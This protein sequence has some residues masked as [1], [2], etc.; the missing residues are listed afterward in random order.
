[1]KRILVVFLGLF[2]LSGL[3]SG[4]VPEWEPI[5]GTEYNMVIFN[6]VTVNGE[7]FTDEG[8][9]MLA[10]FGPGGEDDCRAL[11]GFV[12][13]PNVWNMTAVSTVTA[14]EDLSFKV[15]LANSDIV[16]DCQESIPFVNNTTV[17]GVDDPFGLSAIYSF[18]H[19][20]EIVLPEEFS[21]NEDQSILEDFS[22]Y[23]ND[24]DEEDDLI[25]SCENSE[26]LTV[27]IT[28]M[29]VSITPDANWNGTETLT[30]AVDDQVSG[31]AEADVEIVILP[32][33]DA[34]EFNLPVG[35]SFNED[36]G[37]ELDI[38]DMIWDV[39][40]DDLNILATGDNICIDVL[41]GIATFS[42]TPDWSGIENVTFFADDGVYREM[43]MAVVEVVVTAVNDAP[44]IVGYLPET[45]EIEFVE[46]GSVDFSIEGEDIDSEISYQWLVN[47]IE[48]GTG[49]ELY[50]EFTEVG[51][52][53]VEAVVSD[54]EF[55][56]S[57]LWTVEIME[58]PGLYP[59][60][61]EVV[62]YTN[63][64]VAYCEVTIDGAA[65]ADDD[66]V[67]AFVGDECRGVG[68]IV[69]NNDITVSTMNIQ[70]E[71]LEMI[72]FTVYDASADIVYVSDF[73]VLS[74]PGGDIG[75]PPDLLPVE[76]LTNHPPMIELPQEISLQEDTAE[77][78]DFSYYVSD[79][80]ED[81]L[82]LTC[83]HE[84]NLDVAVDG[85]NVTI[86]PDANW[87]GDELV[88]F[89]VSDDSG[90][91]I[92]EDS[93]NI[94]VFSV[95]DLP[96]LISPLTIQ[97]NENSNYYFQVE[98]GD[99]E[100][101]EIG[102][103]VTGGNNFNINLMP[104]G[105]YSLTNMANWYGED[106]LTVVLTDS[107]GGI[108]EADIS[109]T[110][111]HV[112]HAPQGNHVLLNLN[113]NEYVSLDL[114]D[115]FTDPDGDELTY[116][117]T[118]QYEHLE[119]ELSG[120][121]IEIIPLE[122]SSYHQC[123]IL[124]I[125]D[126]G[127]LSLT[128]GII[129][130]VRE[131]NEPPTA[132]INTNNIVDVQE[133]TPEAIQLYAVDDYTSIADM[134]F[135]IVIQPQHGIFEFI[136]NRRIS[137][138]IEENY[139]GTDNFAVVA[140]DEEGA[141]S[142]TVNC[143]IYIHSV[144]DAPE[145][146]PVVNIWIDS[147]ILEYDFSGNISD[148]ET[149]TEDLVFYPVHTS[150]DDYVAVSGIPY[151]VSGTTI[152]YIMPEN[153]I[154]DIILF[155]I[156][157][158]E[159]E[160]STPEVV[161]VY[162]AGNENT[163]LRFAPLAIDGEFNL[164]YG[165]S[166]DV[167]FSGIDI[168][169]PYE[170]LGIEITSDLQYGVLDDFAFLEYNEPLTTY[171]GS[172][173]P[174]VNEDVTE[175]INFRV[176]GNDGED[177]GT[178]TI[179]ITAGDIAPEIEEISD[180]ELL[181]DT[182]D[183][184]IIN[185]TNPDEAMNLDFWSISSLP[186]VNSMFSFGELTDTT[187]EVVVNPEAD[188]FGT[189]F[190]ELTC[191][192]GNGL[193]DSQGFILT[194]INDNDAPEINLPD[195]F[196]LAE[197]SQL[198]ESFLGY[199]IDIDPDSLSLSVSIAGHLSIEITQILVNITPDAD[200][201]G[202]EMVTFTVNDNQGRAIASDD[203]NIIVTPVNDDPQIDLPASITLME[204]VPE[205][206]DFTPYLTDIDGDVL[207][208][209]PFADPF[210]M[211]SIEGYDV[212]LTPVANWSGITD[213][214]FLVTD[215][216]GGD[217][218]FGAT[219]VTVIEVNDA[220]VIELP[221][222]IEIAEDSSEMID[223]SAY[224]SDLES[225]NLTLSVTG[226][227]EVQVDIDDLEVTFTPSENYY[228]TEMLTF[229]VD[230]NQGRLMASDTVTLDITAVNDAPVIESFEPSEQNI[231]G[232]LNDEITFNVTATDI[233]SELEY[234][235]LIDDIDQNNPEDN[236]TMIFDEP[237]VF[238]VRVDVSDG[239]NS[240]FVVWQVTIAS[241][242]NYNRPWVPVIY[243][244]STVAY[245]EVLIDGEAA[246]IDD[247]VGAFVNYECRGVGEV[248]FDGEYSYATMNIQ[249][250]APEI[251]NFAIYDASAD[252]VLVSE[253]TV[254]SNPGG[255]IGYPPDYLPVYIGE[256]PH[257]DYARPWVPVIYTNSTVAYCEVMINGAAAAVGDEVG[258]F[259]NLECRGVGE[260]FIEREG[261]FATMNIQGIAAEL[262]NFAIYDASADEVLLSEFTVMSNPGGDIGYPPDY[263]P[264][265]I[266]EVPPGDYARP[267]VPVI[268]TNST[269]AYCE[270]MI[271][272]TAADDDDEVGAFVN[273]E[274]RG[275]GD[276]FIDGEHS[277][278]TMNI[279]GNTPELINFAIYNASADE[280]LVSEFTAMSNPGGD[281]GYPPDLLV[282]EVINNHNP[283][284]DLP[285][286][287]ELDEDT[288]LT[289]DFSE[290]ITDVDED[291][292]TLSTDYS[293]FLDISITGLSVIVTPQANWNGQ[294]SV[295]FTVSD[296]QDR[297]I[298]EDT[299][300]FQVNPVNDLPFLVSPLAITFNEDQSSIFTI[301]T[302]DVDNEQVSA[303]LSVGDELNLTLLASNIYRLRS[304]SENWN[305]TTTLWVNLNDN[306]GG[307]VDVEVPVTVNPVNDAP[308]GEYTIDLE[309]GINQ[310]VTIDL[311]DYFNDS[312]GDVLS[313]SLE[314]NYIYHM[315]YELSGS[316]LTLTPAAGFT[317]RA[318][319]RFRAADPA[320]LFTVSAVYM[321][322]IP[323]NTPPVVIN[324]STAYTLMEDQAKS[325]ELLVIDD[326]D[327]Y[328]DLTF[329]ITNP[330]MH[331][332]VTIEDEYLIYEPE[333]NYFGTDQVEIVVHDT[334][335]GTSVPAVFNYMVSP[336]NDRPVSMNREF[337]ITGNT[338]DYDLTEDIFDV[339]TANELL[340]FDSIIT[341]SGDELL[342]VFDVEYT[343]SDWNL[344]YEMPES[345]DVD[346]ICYTLSDAQGYVSRVYNIRIYREGSEGIATRVEPMAING[347][348]WLDYD[349]NM[350]IDF[351]GLD[352]T[353]PMEQLSIEI[354]TEPQYGVLSNFGFFEFNEPLTTYLGNYQPTVNEDI[355]DEIGFRVWGDDGEAFGT[356]S[357]HIAA[358]SIA[359]E[360]EMI[361]D[362]E[363][364]EET[365]GS[366][367][368]N[369]TNPDEDASLDLWSIV[370]IPD[371]NEM[372]SF[373]EITDTTLELEVNPSLDYFGTSLVVITCTDGDGLTDSEGFYL[374]IIN[375]N[376]APE[377]DLP[378]MISFNEDEV[379][380]AYFGIFVNDVD[381]DNLSLSSELAENIQ[382]DII[383]FIV[384]FTPNEDW[385]GSEVVTFTI[386]DNQG[387]AIASDDVIIQ[388]LAVNDDPEINLPVV[389]N[390]MEDI[391]ET[392]DFS[393]YIYDADGDVVETI[394]FANNN[395]MIEVDGYLVTLTPLANWSGTTD[396]A[397]LADDN[398]GGQSAFG[399]TQVIVA[400]VND[401]PVMDLPASVLLDEDSST[402]IDLSDYI[403]DVEGDDLTLSVS[404]NVEIAVEID[405][406]AVTFIP[407]ENYNGSE[408][409]T[410]VVDDNQ[411]RLITTDDMEVIVSP[412]NDEPVIIG[413]E[414]EDQD[415][416]ID[417]ETEISFSVSASDID[418]D[419]EYQWFLNGIDQ[420]NPS[421]E[422]AINFSLAGIYSVSV[423]ISDEEYT[424]SVS[425]QV[426]YS[427]PEDYS[428]PWIPVIYT[429][430]TVAYCEILIEN[431][432]AAEGDEVGAFVN[433]ECRGVGEIFIDSDHSY[434]TMNIQ[435]NASELVNFAV[436][437]ASADEVLLSEFTAMSNP[438]GDIGY[439]P[440]YLPVHIGGGVQGDYARPWVPV[441]YTNS[442][443]AYCQVMIDGENAA[444][445]DEVGA[446]VNYECRGVGEV[447]MEREA[448]YATM[449]IQGEMP[450]LVNFAVY[451]ASADEVLLSEFTAMSNPGG[452]I[453][454]PPNYLPVYIGGGVQGDYA[455]PWVPVIYTNS[456]VA[457]CQ[458]MIDGENAAS[459]DEVGAFVNYECRGVGEVFMEREASYATMNIQGEMPE[460]V[461][462]AVY[463][464]SADEV[465]LSEFT[466]MSN[467]GG[468]IGYPPNYLPVYIGGGVQGDYARPWVPVIYTNSTVAY[469]QVMIDGENAVAGDEVG[470]FVN[471]E[472]RGVGEVFMEREASYATMNIQGEMPELVNFAVYDVSADEVLISE[473]TAMSNPGYDIGYPPAYL[474]VY[475]GGVVQGDYARPWVPVIYTNSTVAYCQVMIDGE[476][477]ASGDEVG[478]FV[479]Y[480]CR[481]V[482]EVFIEREASYATMNIQGELPE[483]V[484]F[485]VYDASADEVLISEFTAMS[486]PGYDIGYPP[487]YLPV[488]VG[489]VQGD[490]ARPWVPV[491]YT[492]STVAYCQVMID[493][494]N[495]ASGDEVGAFVN[496]ECRGVG[497]V[498]ME[499][500]A[501]Y[502]TM[503]IQGE[504]PELVNFAV[505]DASAD[506]VL[507][508]E[509]TAM[510]NPGYDI[511]YPPAYLPVYVGGVQGDYARP[512]VPVIY[513]N[514]T[515][516]YCQVMI[517]GENAVSGD[518]VGAFV[519]YECRGVGEVFM[520]REASYATMNIQGEMPELVNFAVYDVSADEVLISEFTA[521][522]NP[523]YDIGYPPA[524]LPVYVGG[525]VQGDYARPWVPVIYTNSTVAYCQVMIDGEN[526][527][528]GDE[529]G[530]FVNYE[531]RGVGEVF[532]EREASYATMN[533]QGEMPEL[534]N[535][536]VYDASADE[537]LISEFTAMSNPGYDIG[538]PPAYLPVYV[539]GVQGDYARPWVPVIYTNSTVAYCQVMIDGENAAS[540]DEV[541]AFVNYECRGVGEVFMERE[542][543]YAT[544]NIQG[545]MPELVNFAVYDASA[546]EVLISEFTAM[547]NPGYDIGYPP[548]YLPV[549]VGSG[550]QSDFPR[551][552]NLVIYP[553]STVAYC[554]VIMNGI[555]ASTSD[556]VGV[557]VLSE[558]RGLGN[559]VLDEGM[560]YSTI[561]VQ[562]VEVELLQFAVWD[563]SSDQVYVSDYTTFSNPGGDI[564]YPPDLLPIYVGQEMPTDFPR[565]WNV[566]IYTNSTVAYCEVTVFGNRAALDDEVAAFVGYECRGIGE[567]NYSDDMSVS[568][569]SIQGEIP[570]PV[571]FAVW[572]A[573]LDVVLVAE[574]N[575]TTIPGGDLGYPPDLLPISVGEELPNEFPRPWQ[576]VIYPNSTVA[577]CEVT[578]NDGIASQ[579]DEIAAFAGTECRGTGEIIFLD[580][581]SYSTLNI[582]GE[583][584]EIIQFALWDS[585]LDDVYVSDYLV[586]SNP[587]HDLGYPPDFLPLDFSTNNTIVHPPVIDLPE[588]ITLI[589][590]GSR[591]INL[592][593]YVSGS[594][595][596]TL[597]LEAAPELGATIS[598]RT[599]IINPIDNWNGVEPITVYAVS[600]GAVSFD[601]MNVSVTPVNDAPLLT[602]PFETL[603]LEEDFAQ[604]EIDL[605]VHF[606]DVENDP[607]TFAVDFD[608]NEIQT[609]LA[610]GIMTISSLAN[611]HGSTTISV[612]VND[613][614][615]RAVTSA[616]FL[617]QVLAVN[618]LPVINLPESFNFNEDSSITVNFAPYVSDIDGDL[619]T[620][621]LEDNDY[622]NAQI[623]GK[624]VTLSAI[625]D[626]YGTETVTFSVSD[627][628]AR[629]IVSD[630]TEI[631]VTNIN[632]SP[633][634]ITPLADIVVMEDYI[635]TMINL[636]DYFI[637]VD[638]DTLQ[639][640]YTNNQPQLTVILEN[641]IMTISSA[642]NWS[643]QGTI[644]VT[645]GD[646][647][648]QVSDSFV[649]TVTPSNDGPVIND[650][651]PANANLS[652]YREETVD[653]SVDAYD[654][655]SQI[656]YN[657]YSN[658]E[659][660][661]EMSS[662]LSY[663]FNEVWPTQISVTVSDQEFEL[664]QSW[665]VEV[666]LNEDWLP[667]VYTNSTV[668]YGS[669]MINGQQANMEDV[670]GAFVDNECRGA[671]NI[672]M[673]DDL[674]YVSMNIQGEIIEEVE[675]RVWDAG[676]N[677]IYDGVY[678]TL[679]NP[680]GDIGTPED[681][682][683][684]HVM[685][686]QYPEIDLPDGGFI[687]N[688]DT[689]LTINFEQYVSDPDGDSL[690]ITYSGN[691]EINIQVEN[692]LLVTLSANANWNG[693]ENIEF[694]VNDGF[695]G[696][697][698][699][700][701]PVNVVAVNDN[702][703]LILPFADLEMLE[704]AEPLEI[705]LALHFSDIDTDSL[706]YTASY[707]NTHV[708]LAILNG[709]MTLAPKPNWNGVTQ[710]SVT[711]N[712]G[713]MNISD[714]F[715]LTVI[716]VNDLPEMVLPF[717]DITKMEDF[718]TF[719]LN[720]SSHFNDIDNNELIYQINYQVEEIGAVLVGE[721]VYISSVANWNGTAVLN[722][723]AYDDPGNTPATAAVNIIV[724]PENDVPQINLPDEFSF[725]E[726]TELIEDF[727]QYIFDVDMDDLTLTAS[728]TMNINV[729]IAG[730]T[731][732]L[733]APENYNGS[734]FVTFTV[735]DQEGRLIAS[736][737]TMLTVT[738]L[739]DPPYIVDDPITT[740]EFDEDSGYQF[741][742]GSVFADPD[743]PYGDQL[744]YQVSGN[745]DVIVEFS[746][747]VVNLSATENWAGTEVLQFTAIDFD[748][749]SVSHN[750]SVM[751][752]P[753]NDVP[754]IA[755]SL[756]VY[757]LEEDF[758]GFSLNM[759]NFFAD[760]DNDVLEY[761]IEYN[762]EE[763]TVQITDSILEI[764]SISNWY[765]TTA[766]TVVAEDGITRASVSGD[767]ILNVVTIND[768][769]EINLPETLT[770]QEDGSSYLNLQ[771]YVFDID[772]DVLT[773][774]VA[775]NVNINITI[776]AMIAEISAAPDWNGQELVT[777]FVNDGHDRV[778][779][780]DDILI[781]VTAV[782][783]APVLNLPATLSFDE[784]TSA[785]LDLSLYASDVDG[786]DLTAVLLN[787]NNVDV[788]F[789]GLTATFSALENWF[790]NENVT[791]GITDGV[792][793]PP[794]SDMII[795]TVNPI[796][797]PPQL[798]LPA[799]LSFAEDGS[800]I[801][802][803]AL[804][805]TDIDSDDFL[806]TI[807]PTDGLIVSITGLNAVVTA[808]PD[809]NGTGSL[810]VNISDLDGG[811]ANDDMNIIVTPVNDPPYI[812]VQIPDPYTVEEDFDPVVLDLNDYYN[813]V[814]GDILSYEVD[815]NETD[816]QIDLTG[817]IATISPVANWFGETTITLTVSDNQGRAQIV[818]S[819]MLIVTSVND[820]PEL[821]LPAEVSFNEDGSL[822]F[823][824]S[825]YA[826]DVEGDELICTIT[827]NTEI[828]AQ[829]F[830]MTIL[831]S[832]TE[833]WNGSEIVSIFVDDAIAREIYR[834][835][836]IVTVNPV[837]DP[838]EIVS[839]EPAETELEI[840]QHSSI[841]FH[842]EVTDIDS[843]PVFAWTVNSQTAGDDL[844]DLSYSFE[845]HGTFTV[846][847]HLTDGSYS[848]NVVWTV[849]VEE[850]ENDG[851]EILPAVTEIIGNYPN[852]FNPVTTLEFAVRADQQIR[853][854]VYNSRGQFIRNLV[855][856]EFQ[857][858]IH[859]VIWDGRDEK[860]NYQ[861]SG[862]YYFR[863]ISAEGRDI[864]KALLLK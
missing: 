253:F 483:L 465:L 81:E 770:F 391:P 557:F 674:A 803:F 646:G 400:A 663:T 362:Y 267:W 833:N 231:S 405:E 177:F 265:Y 840:L 702:P 652:V 254:M 606:A 364:M 800:L 796:N 270:V 50:Y 467:P 433:F 431:E 545:E 750:I 246:A 244:N 10:A 69:V 164:N 542:A 247:E 223:F 138:L 357:I 657:W 159:N 499:R 371:I 4:E 330:A 280:V 486:N 143:D 725:A 697:D 116:N 765:G 768:P 559:I 422:L 245:C 566:I 145:V 80:D 63:S 345:R 202:E 816:I 847:C 641:G 468:D 385:F 95:N 232:E 480:E 273:Y 198:Q 173:T 114:D 636:G 427:L 128:K 780:S 218:G 438:G 568:T 607:L 837:N 163:G 863:M 305:G 123:I 740:I 511:G 167:D 742:L 696:M 111:L 781:S 217:S 355:T 601:I 451:D 203:V 112:N 759:N 430:S 315:S 754:Y 552:W 191:T 294:A 785:A 533:I 643:G 165:G 210:I 490:Y 567:I 719:S 553:N 318:I 680:G 472:C 497:E 146:E 379:Y 734:E 298:A 581:S 249:G 849:Y 262:V 222:V 320:G 233:D 171:L 852:P 788:E 190:V 436:Y 129:L 469:C 621:V 809:W 819:F 90:R 261:S 175:I 843:D 70:G 183:S 14:G 784:D 851:T 295:T 832:A 274:C 374:T 786:D 316:E 139:E 429:N 598:G 307:E 668:A 259:V 46:S 411:G 479:N 417:V 228:G 798:E 77:V 349:M 324:N 125:E 142:D 8:S 306:A 141:V 16:I 743:L 287:I 492:N 432:V 248:F 825:E 758:E 331:G 692:G 439:P 493:G 334:D 505:Y 585:D 854:D 104:A 184:F 408:L 67:G 304:S 361:A 204:D 423:E 639:Y 83:D 134:E 630:Q 338:L 256:I 275:V 85:F 804:Y 389:I 821:N 268:Y 309:T 392:R 447:F 396:I 252:E 588:T 617:V 810:T 593:Q 380:E 774:E 213:L 521:M 332:S 327:T 526:A 501:S 340:T 343:L 21:G 718:T 856:A 409:M 736:D 257:V 669:V 532:M 491:I 5:S 186:D 562:G 733:S 185:Y 289:V 684:I 752:V 846:R 155:R 457:Y 599:L 303:E 753:V 586:M 344:H 299:V 260:I 76:I 15:Y 434:A 26:H 835:D 388:V 350:E 795:V 135:E 769:P 437:D 570:E 714:T 284:I 132:F 751:V 685:A 644:T 82:T 691:D 815:Y 384:T 326:N 484:N 212:T 470:A 857:K 560:S 693:I 530:A 539:G 279:Q 92:A 603:I 678:T 767:I 622:I 671:A 445:G 744:T 460:L 30:F 6:T 150:G 461:N 207:E 406:L 300:I 230:D 105:V 352:L 127:G 452:D 705:N 583:V 117:I 520:E 29:L 681:P 28:G 314:N 826:F 794:T 140:I 498:F 594:T 482:G 170:Q 426:T 390:M 214:G 793:F 516:A 661:S 507:I 45:T 68:N 709:V 97:F 609:S 199:I 278:A 853:I 805:L 20:P 746:G 402:S 34:P 748:L 424:E 538:Y 414:P 576:V 25:L 676:N 529:V 297:A 354:T 638:S 822:A 325:I 563:A 827:G 66:E 760:Y 93:V 121:I 543:S 596:Y 757:D 62:N 35:L 712:D 698:S 731:V 36:E 442:T 336:V 551:P 485:A 561:N 56:I 771:Q 732:T 277:Y 766:I 688:E 582:Q 12:P 623:T 629:A 701:V 329:E 525:G 296:N 584:S 395:I 720:L 224:V 524:Y 94:V 635:P 706:T 118:S 858:G 23:I 269:V 407:A 65:A 459:G 616:S 707:A 624:I 670:V 556:E 522:S 250:N 650:Y 573:S 178:I 11:A 859:K 448:S 645:A 495:A 47:E 464:A 227:V 673:S 263:L 421:S 158:E 59:R 773:F 290:Y 308:T 591:I 458:V 43:S 52:Y 745:M 346:F 704:D 637:D 789:D 534:V 703:L 695:D 311:N 546:D 658:G 366:L 215:N 812:E 271:N 377:I 610:E 373:A 37:Y 813:D 372:L 41:D 378:E 235:W 729:Q 122:A 737:Q 188:Y 690:F 836:M 544:M 514:S 519:N 351:N 455:R 156:L 162:R 110:V 195:E 79:P 724:L 510:S 605:N 564:G 494:E 549:Y 404:G 618:D 604:F 24:P 282:I 193:S 739:N 777:F 42:S 258:A 172:Y 839:F 558:C 89:R 211:I 192:D 571:Q 310:A 602:V 394:P 435:G 40:G 471:Y 44:V 283:V 528:S 201:N 802:D 137:Y 157:D 174:T 348:V 547:S 587:G 689:E 595:S 415:I 446:F 130:S 115:Y 107:D 242:E 580:G 614:V 506:E 651:T 276:V 611:W 640:S 749:A 61:W 347:N 694:I 829:I 64:T 454:Y 98:A 679:T 182:S 398:Q 713:I 811:Y 401:A 830:G 75:Y 579:G 569:I 206:I 675:F 251:V 100:S 342:S 540:G 149:P 518:E 536:A 91:L 627:N 208:I 686:N 513:T 13:G 590:D 428:R 548:A 370:S 133:D 161:W 500:E 236:L 234:Q 592:A 301:T 716:A 168:T 817:S 87:F 503:N 313:Y 51:S 291:E 88:I 449:N 317:G 196:S 648:F 19:L 860:N 589:E 844:P 478:A 807:E 450:E 176:F 58:D 237:G 779:V 850:S 664:T 615:N 440:N 489:G 845:Q 475:V 1:M 48:T 3:L 730:L 312:D 38:T 634:L 383:D 189:S 108:T 57:Q 628:Q 420:N 633:F 71:T 654:P 808:E 722:I 444:S 319:G 721:V 103:S 761:S 828:N 144:N 649:Y 152:T 441:I 531:C 337:M 160:A 509:F 238:I 49:M 335:G 613:N 848:Y 200:W 131:V 60:P 266:G 600:G 31:E 151:T 381:F 700:I 126:P 124:N 711:A 243:T 578:I 555:P 474:P 333:V 365:S 220:P 659:M 120:S 612:N 241:P 626:W 682:L 209:I 33:N 715:T 353:E 473:F 166:T 113:V 32:V 54:E 99:V 109:V 387:R 708:N 462:Y 776:T 738:G 662:S 219:E 831:F 403:S 359:P 154:S 456:T 74:N 255:D 86:T 824:V 512:W 226:N 726:E 756:P 229:S 413:Y 17:G 792:A 179:N 487:A 619:L 9:N 425:W 239:D 205:V 801:I 293:G 537:V 281:I 382:I 550:L 504:M 864:S 393:Q 806:M 285:A 360:I 55:S 764:N 572:D 772:Q 660:L 790:G 466:A 356:I 187:L 102:I 842:L 565:P 775:G 453:G 169:E 72:T 7:N 841:D 687:F 717:N 225:D 147:D 620:L 823:D 369:Y 419:L 656:T 197:D 341:G 73:T 322:V 527:V 397:F 2:F 631:I 667:V 747:S 574:Y 463:D 672:F 302:G 763:V 517:D 577:Y 653:F 39:D 136:N 363:T 477:A 728:E 575:T 787:S 862:I 608:D 838:P 535:F 78:F 367:T 741:N 106:N 735:N 820:L 181:E 515:V 148:E 632:D 778:I 834:Q 358:V 727:E 496:Y 683:P 410:F 699:E 710:I 597:N 508:S 443:V 855:N 292:I 797:D 119:V 216:M 27:E 53:T 488:Y 762:E 84:G 861:P 321:Q 418:S 399:A 783:D 799:E 554:Q 240:L 523:G 755:V 288:E 375:D 376:D 194:V 22:S 541:G 264:V 814:D 221:D 791:L 272:G 481:G 818:D 180:F 286:V 625:A 412:V 368:I 386:D 666:Y 655:D 323:V 677:R 18:N 153:R 502:A 328:A 782:N 96:Y 476:N 416:V 647:E 339:E 101:S 723:S 642:E 665:N